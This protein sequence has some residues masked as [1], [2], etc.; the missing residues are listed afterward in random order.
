MTQGREEA[1]VP[2]SEKEEVVG[3]AGMEGGHRI[4]ARESSRG[5]G[6]KFKIRPPETVG[7][8]WGETEGGRKC[9][10]RVTGEVVFRKGGETDGQSGVQKDS[11]R[12]RWYQKEV[13]GDPLEFSS[14]SLV[15]RLD[16][17]REVF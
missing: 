4:E 13:G 3:L 1:E 5:P 6:K 11:G 14:G 16:G 7:G 8:D 2:C 9:R 15:G 17:S 12:F 10:G